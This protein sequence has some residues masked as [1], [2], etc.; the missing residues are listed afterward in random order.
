MCNQCIDKA[1]KEDRCRHCEH[2]DYECTLTKPRKKRLYGSADHVRAQ[3]AVLE[4]LV[5]GLIPNADLSTLDSMQEV[6]RILGIPLP[7]MGD[8]KSQSTQNRQGRDGA[9]VFVEQNQRLVQDQQGQG[10]YIGPAISY[11]F[12]LKLRTLLGRRPQR[13]TCQMYLFGC[14]PTEETLK[15]SASTIVS[16]VDVRVVAQPLQ[17]DFI[18]G[19]A[20]HPHLLLDT[21]VIGGLIQSYFDHVNV[22]FPVL[23]KASFLEASEY[24]RADAKSVD[25]AWVCGLLCVLILGRRINPAGT[26]QTQQQ[27]WWTHIKSLL[28]TIIFTS[29][30]Q[31][32][33]ALMLTALHLHNTNHRN[34]CWT[35]TG[36]AV[37]IAIAIGLDRDEVI[38]E[39]PQVNQELRKSLRWT[40][41][42]FEQI[43]VS[44]HDRPSALEGAVCSTKPPIQRIL[45][46]GSSSH[47]PEYILWSTRLVSILGLACRTLPAASNQV[48]STGP[49]SPVAGLLRDL[50]RW[51]G[52]LPQHLSMRVFNTIPAAFQRSVLLLHIQYHY[53]VFLLTRYPL[54]QHLATM[55]EESSSDPKQKEIE[56]TAQICC[57][58]GRKSCELL[59]QLDQTGNFNAVTWLDVYFVYS[60]TLVLTLSIMRDRAR[61]ESE[62]SSDNG[63]LSL[64]YDCAAMVS[65]HSG[66]PMMPGTMRRWVGIICDLNMLVQERLGSLQQ[67]PSNDEGGSV[68]HSNA[69]TPFVQLGSSSK[70]R[71]FPVP[72]MGMGVQHSTEYNFAK[73]D[74]SSSTTDGECTGTTPVTPFIDDDNAFFSWDSI[75]SMLL[76]TETLDSALIDYSFG[77]QY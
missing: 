10:Q 3:I 72:Y 58:S 41:Y 73:G 17:S 47:P 63:S 50:S 40:L 32:I 46:V 28:P 6:A 39:G 25:P 43:Q 55:P 16:E 26:M 22:D 44:S 19:A 34:A 62:E 49:L 69:A 36:A 2:F 18:A 14:N 37:R 54:L 30:I 11:F 9:S 45:G 68:V 27:R 65:R 57:E 71:Y 31:S 64:L 35:L 59:L 33:Q 42:G 66:N 8:G 77:Y 76:G 20:Q 56:S 7:E 75:A 51:Y 13:Q 21:S 48:N 29:S 4:A 61:Q 70:T 12:Q 74:R 24:W 1:K 5:K 38:C 60:S 23:H 15:P 53:N 67:A 52:S